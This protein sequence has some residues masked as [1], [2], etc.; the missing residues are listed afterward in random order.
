[1]V[2]TFELKI[3]ALDLDSMEQNLNAMRVTISEKVL[4]I[5]ETVVILE[6]S[7]TTLAYEWK[8][9]KDGC[10]DVNV[11]NSDG[12]YGKGLGKESRG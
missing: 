2:C 9:W 11:R 6:M 1:M 5:S 7:E 8:Y 4:R 10:K 12:T 3:H